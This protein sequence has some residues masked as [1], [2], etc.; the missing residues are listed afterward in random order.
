MTTGRPDSL[1]A[2]RD[3]YHDLIARWPTETGKPPDHFHKLGWEAGIAYARDQE[4]ADCREQVRLLRTALHQIAF[5]LR[6]SSSM[7]IAARQAL[8][9]PGHEPYQNQTAR[10]MILEWAS[11]S[12]GG[13]VVVQELAHALTHNSLYDSTTDASRML[14][15]TISRMTQA[16]QLVKVSRG[17]YK[18]EEQV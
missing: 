13:T 5:D 3:H 1:Q 10:Q 8:Q 9:P 17:I 2:E 14:Y 4:D 7:R 6:N 18:L 16:G 15:A 11:R 12:P